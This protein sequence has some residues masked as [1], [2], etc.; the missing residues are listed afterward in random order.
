MY[1]T[2]VTLSHLVAESFPQLAKITGADSIK[3]LASGKWSR[4][5]ILGHLIDSASN[6]HQRF[7]RAQLAESLSFPEYEQEGWVQSQQYQH[8]SWT[9]LV[10]LW[11]SY[12]LHLAHI[13]ANIPEEKLNN[14]VTVGDDEP[15]TLRFLVED[16]VRHLRHHLAQILPEFEVS[17]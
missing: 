1:D 13:I 7:V 5:Q 4:K 8:E 3:S 15:V 2:V 12:N 16:Y 9:D 14:C 17:S 11:K 10:A 6:N